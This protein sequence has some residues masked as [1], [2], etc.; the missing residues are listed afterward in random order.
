MARVTLKKESSTP[1]TPP[2][3]YGSLYI[4]GTNVI[5]ID[6]TG[7]TRP[8][9]VSITQVSD[10]TLITTTSTSYVLVTGMTITPAAGTYFVR[11]RILTSATS[12]SRYTY[13]AIFK[14]STIVNNTEVF[15]F[16]RTGAG[17]LSNSDVENL[18]TDA[19]VTL[20]GSEAIN[21]RWYTTGGTAQAQGY[22]LS[23]TRT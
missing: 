16:I 13:S 18:Y 6:D 23:I 8:L 2:S 12:N 1:A 17:I 22:S 15:G 19:I 10:N 14:D 9:N 21:L 4:Q 3:N 11:G 7:T 20:N 5:F